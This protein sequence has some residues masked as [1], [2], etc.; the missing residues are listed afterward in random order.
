MYRMSAGREVAVRQG[1]LFSAEYKQSSRYRYL[2]KVDPI[3]FRDGCNLFF[4]AG[5]VDNA[6]VE[7]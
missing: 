7:V 6:F 4:S 5:K 1:N 2:A 3:S